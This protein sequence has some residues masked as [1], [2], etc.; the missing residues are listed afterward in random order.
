MHPRTLVGHPLALPFRNATFDVMATSPTCGDRMADHHAPVKARQRTYPQD[1]R[2]RL[3]SHHSGQLEW[4][5][6]YREFHEAAW[7]EAL[8]VLRP[9]GVLDL[10]VRDHVRK[11]EIQP[12]TE[13]HVATLER[14]GLRLSDRRSLLA[15]SFRDGQ[16][17]D[18]RVD[19]ESVLRFER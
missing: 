5:P 18:A 17:G 15:P 14:L 10:N 6:R 12:V 19:H 13:W 2:C 4:G 8:R 1:L 3:N 11:D 9:G 7:A 16:N